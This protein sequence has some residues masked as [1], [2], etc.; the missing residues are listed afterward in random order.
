[1]PSFVASTVLVFTRL[2]TA[3]HINDDQR[4]VSIALDRIDHTLDR[5][6]RRFI[7][8]I[9]QIFRLVGWRG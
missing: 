9:V 8:D 2:R 4:G 6:L 3:K 1:M 7:L 5:L